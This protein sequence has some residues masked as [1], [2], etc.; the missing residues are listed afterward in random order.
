MITVTKLRVI[1]FEVQLK[2]MPAQKNIKPNT[3]KITETVWTYRYYGGGVMKI[4]VLTSQPY[5]T[6][7]DKGIHTGCI[8]ISK[9]KSFYTQ[10]LKKREN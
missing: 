5:R 10:L 2:F 7:T 8:F 3:M 6:F 4:P 9:E 1:H